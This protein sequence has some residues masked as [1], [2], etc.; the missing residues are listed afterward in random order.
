MPNTTTANLPEE[1]QDVIAA[2]L[3]VRPDD[4]Y[5]FAAFGP[6]QDES[7]ELN[8]EGVASVNFNKPI[9]QGGTMTELSRRLVEDTDIGAGSIALDEDA[10]TLTTR[11]YGGPHDGANVLPFG[12]REFLASLARHDLAERIGDM[13]KRDVNRFQ[14]RVYM[15]LLLSGTYIAPNAAAE[16]AITAGQL[17][18]VAF[19]RKIAKTMKE[20]KIPK[21]PDGRYRAIL[22]VKDE[23]DL[24][25]D[26]EYQA[27]ARELG[28]QNPQFAGHIANLEGFQI[29]TS[30][31][32]Y[33]KMVGAASAV[34]GYQSSFFGPYGIGH[35]TGMAPQPR[36]RAENDFG[37]KLH[38]LWKSHEAFGNLYPELIYRSITT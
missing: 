24:K 19:L 3:L 13:L 22:S 9:H 32:L 37:R 28:P 12:L 30:T 17:F 1:I 16:G 20:A 6:I 38:A 11:E 34:T 18:T 15:D 23:F 2:K 4:E 35:G 31:H 36:F 21:Y 26:T 27:I 14:D 25:A 8:K 33:T 5:I 29:G 10:V 7:A